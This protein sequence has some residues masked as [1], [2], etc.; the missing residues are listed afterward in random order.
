ML[1]NCGAGE[2]AWQYLGLQGNQTTQSW[3]DLCRSWN[4]NTLATWF[5]EPTHWQRL[6]C[7][8]RLWGDRGWDG[9]K[10]SLTQR[11]WVSANSV[12]QWIGKPGLLKSMGWQRV[13]PDFATEQQEVTVLKTAALNWGWFCPPPYVTFINLWRQFC[14]PSGRGF[15]ISYKQRTETVL[16]ILQSTRRHH[17]KKCKELLAQNINSA[18]VEKFWL[19]VSCIQFRIVNCLENRYPEYP[20]DVLKITSC[21]GCVK[22]FLSF[23]RS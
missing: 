18:K 16:N 19:K 21:T 1:S 11:T 14:C 12:R 3:K 23:Q 6:W 8:E 2:D 15:L 13:K 5:K 9:W 22:V 17:S 20:F 10:A 7:W 4:S